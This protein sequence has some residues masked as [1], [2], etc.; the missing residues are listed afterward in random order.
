MLL[1]NALFKSGK[2]RAF[3]L[4]I[5]TPISQS[6][7]SFSSLIQVPFLNLIANIVA[8][9]G[10]FMIRVGGNTQE[11]AEVIYDTIPNGRVLE[12]NLTGVSNPVRHRCQ[13]TRL[14]FS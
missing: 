10:S 3:V 7:T 6:Q 14:L 13:Y 8:R 2:I 4:A 9:T 11:T 12:K 5:C 1:K